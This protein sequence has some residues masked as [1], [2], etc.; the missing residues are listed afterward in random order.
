MT[1]ANQSSVNCAQSVNGSEALIA[2]SDIPIPQNNPDGRT[3]PS[4]LS[5]GG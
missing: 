5:F 3:Q 1:T 2:M 4:I